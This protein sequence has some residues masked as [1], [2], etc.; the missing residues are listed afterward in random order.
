[1][2]RLFVELPSFWK[3]W[4]GYGLT[5]E[6]LR[7]MQN[8]LETNPNTGKLV[9]GTGGVRKLRYAREHRGKSGGVRVMYVDFPQFEKLFF[10]AVYSKNEK[11]NIS[12]AERNALKK[13]A[14][15]LESEVMIEP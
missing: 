6:D 1:M 9:I 8:D 10:L 11:D 13:L 14:R 2:P 3:D 5:D 15:I 7:K 4:V 12:M